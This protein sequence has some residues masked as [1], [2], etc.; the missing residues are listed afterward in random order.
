MAMKMKDIKGLKSIL[1][2]FKTRQVRYGGYAALITLAVII[3]LILLNLIIGQFSPQIDMTEGGLFSLSDQTGQVVD[4]IK[5][6]VNLYGLWRPGD[7]NPQLMEV[8]NLY[9]AKNRNIRLEVVDPNKNPGLVSKFDKTNQGVQQG[10]LVVEGEKGFKIISPSD[11]YDYMYT[12]NNTRNVTGLAMERRITAALLFVATGQTP[13]VYEIMGHQEYSLY[14]LQMQA[15]VE[16]ENFDVSQLNLVQSPIPPD[17]SI[18]FLNSPRWDLSRGEADKILDY[19]EKGGRLLV[20][21]DY[22]IRELP[23]LNEIM[24]SY[25]MQFDFGYLM[26][27]NPNYTAGAYYL[28]IPDMPEHD[29]TKPLMEQRTP[30]LL[31]FGMGISET[32]AKRR[33]VELKPLLTSSYDSFLRTDLEELSTARISTDIPGPIIMGMTAMDPSWIDPN[34]PAPQTR[35]AAIACGSLL[36]PVSYFGQIPGNI[37]L[38]MNSI[39]WL[40]DRPETLTV[41]SKS[42]FLLPMRINGFL[43]IVYGVFFVIVIPVGFFIAGFIIWL[44]R[45]HL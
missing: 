11:M 19:L 37:D 14:D 31:A 6:P 7:E 25:G 3:G 12:Q 28:A 34:N 22:R 24:A 15:L 29:I 42:M 10:S 9:L 33:S 23:I 41:R 39:T 32:A 45:R 35:I 13:T 44:R 1:D 20:L 26:E 18:L 38:F 5:T 4:Q 27:N 2:S 40:Q 8:V 16:R 43:M 36:E 30:V 17:A 21:A